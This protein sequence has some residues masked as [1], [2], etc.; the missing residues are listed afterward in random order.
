MILRISSTNQDCSIDK[1]L[2]YQQFEVAITAKFCYG[3]N[4]TRFSIKN[5]G[6]LGI[7]F[8]LFV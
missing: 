5:K 8:A 1:K 7:I 4:Y 2:L 3:N 6:S